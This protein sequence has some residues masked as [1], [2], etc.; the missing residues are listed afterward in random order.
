M[1]QRSRREEYSEA[2]RTALID[3]ARRN[4][5]A[6][7]YAATAIETVAREARVTRGALYHHFADKRALFEAVVR[8]TQADLVRQ[9]DEA[10]LRQA[11]GPFERLDA[12]LAA[13]LH[14]SHAS[15]YRRIV[16][17]DAPS[18]LGWQRWREID[19][20]FALGNLT[21]GLQALIDA[22]LLRPVPAELFAHLLMGAF[23]EVALM[24]ASAA[25]PDTTAVEARKLLM[26]F[27]AASAP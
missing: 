17:E 24:V 25:D 6:N 11:G 16:L 9:V 15:D 23:A 21:T 1:Q 10:A 14:A 4:F 5:A 20:D 2:T 7:G 13:F 27:I 3:A 18:V 22:G 8:E 26:S 12:G 19:N